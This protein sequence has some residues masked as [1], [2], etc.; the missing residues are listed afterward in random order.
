MN[1]PLKYRGGIQTIFQR[2]ESSTFFGREIGLM[3]IHEHIRYAESQARLGN[4]ETF[5]FALR[6][7]IPI[8]YQH[9]VPCGDFRQSNCYYSSSDVTFKN[10]YEADERYD[11]IKT[12]TILLKGGW[13]IYSS[14]PGIYISLIIRRLL[15]LR[16]E[17]E[18][19]I[20]DPVLPYSLDGISVSLNFLGKKLLLKYFVVTS[21]Y[22]PKSLIIN[23]NRIEYSLEENAYR[24]GGAVLPLI[25]FLQL[26]D[27]PENTIEIHL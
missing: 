8:E 22:S 18:Q 7:A 19:V 12:G 17:S 23:G 13:R 27:Q 3:Y 25:R 10:R 11:E 6:Q 15:G 2:A 1:R 26:V 20:L 16:I 14:G 4:A 5:L 24:A 21:E 9:I